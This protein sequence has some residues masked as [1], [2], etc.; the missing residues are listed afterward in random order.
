MCDITIFGTQK[1]AFCKFE[2]I[3]RIIIHHAGFGVS[4]DT[5]EILST[6]C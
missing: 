6:R 4:E 5:E 3:E 1:K 2:D